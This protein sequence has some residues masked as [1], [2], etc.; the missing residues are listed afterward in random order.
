MHSTAGAVLE[1][2]WT[3]VSRHLPEPVEAAS[4]FY[5]LVASGVLFVGLFLIR[6]I[7]EWLVR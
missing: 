7:L 2:E 3:N 5:V 1:K 4:A 6:P